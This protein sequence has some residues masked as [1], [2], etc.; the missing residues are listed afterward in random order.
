MAFITPDERQVLQVPSL[1]DR[2]LYA[3]GRGY[4]LSDL[5]V[6][7]GAMDAT[8]LKRFRQSACN[9]PVALQILGLNKPKDGSSAQPKPRFPPKTPPSS[10]ESFATE[11]HP[12]PGKNLTRPPRPAA[13]WSKLDQPSQLPQKDGKVDMTQY[14]KYKEGGLRQ[15][16]HQAI[17]AK[18]C[19]RCWSS[20][21]LRSSR[22]EPPKK[23]EE[24]YNKGKAAFWGPRS[25]QPQSRPQW[26]ARPPIETT[27]TLSSYLLF[28]TD[29]GRRI[30]LDTCSDISIGHKK[31]LK[32]LRL[33]KQAVF[34]E[35][36]GGT[37]L[38]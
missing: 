18:Q 19:I 34:V 1:A 21:H 37:C 27:P 28:A 17:R 14:G 38:F 25:K 35:G 12:K 24:D 26:F 15:K 4:T 29:S 6:A 30:A 16:I 8:T 10:K 7:I 23:W 32:N 31:I 3:N 11:L 20:D 33:V 13:D 2:A 9:D 5:E 36:V 22:P